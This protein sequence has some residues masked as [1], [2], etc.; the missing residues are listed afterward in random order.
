MHHSYKIG[1]C[2]SLIIII[3]CLLS[4]AT[5]T[6]SSVDV[7][8]ICASPRD[9]GPG[10]FQCP[11]ENAKKHNLGEWDYLLRAP[12][13]QTQQI[14]ELTFVHKRRMALKKTWLNLVKRAL[15]FYRSTWRSNWS[16][17]VRG[18]EVSN[19]VATCS[20]GFRC[21]LWLRVVLQARMRTGL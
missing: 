19:Y 3:T 14:L 1:K 11:Y 18:K 9:G 20:S 2:T 6:R 10:N 8:F 4:H 21:G 13:V 16:T 5:H 7:A 12:R 17:I 15:C